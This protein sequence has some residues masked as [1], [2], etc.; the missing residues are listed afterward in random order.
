M[1]W[2]VRL[3][4]RNLSIADKIAKGR[5]IVTAMTNNTTFQ[6]PHPPLQDVTT[7]W[8]TVEFESYLRAFCFAFSDRVE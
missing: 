4:L 3:N 6:T 1:L 7:L 5:Q 2:R 8:T